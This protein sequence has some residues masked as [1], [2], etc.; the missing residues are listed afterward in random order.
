MAFDRLR[1]HSFDC[2]QPEGVV[3]DRQ[4]LEDLARVALEDGVVQPHVVLLPHFEDHLGRAVLGVQVV[5]PIFQLY[6]YLELV[7]LDVVHPVE[8][9][10]FKRVCLGFG[11]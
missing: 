5:L 6:L 4:V 7:A 3:V 11:H 1:G 9:D 10:L 2:L 8:Q